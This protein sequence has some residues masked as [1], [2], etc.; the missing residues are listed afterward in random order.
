MSTFDIITDAPGMLRSEAVNIT[1]SFNRTSPTTGRVSWNIPTPAAGCTSA[2]QAYCGIVITV[3]NKPISTGTGP[4]D[5]TVYNSDPTADAN[6]FA[7]DVIGTAKVVGAFYNDRTTTFLD[8]TGLQPNT[9]VYVS[10]FPTDCQF[11]YYY[12]GVHAYS[13]N[14][15]NRGTDG[16]HGHQVLVLNSSASQMGVQPTDAT[17]LVPGTMYSFKIQLGLIP[18]PNR[19]IDQTECLPQP[20][21][22]TITV[23]GADAQT[24]ADLVAAINKQFGLLSNAAL[25]PTS[26]NTNGYYFNVTQKLLFQWNG[27][28]HVAVPCIISATAPNAVLT[29]GY[30][31]NTSTNVMSVWTGSAWSTV[32]VISFSSDPTQPVADSSYWFDGTHAY[33]WNGTTWCQVATYIQ[34]TDP[35]LAT[36]PVAGSYWYDT[37]DHLLYRWNSTLEMWSITPV[38][39]YGT[40]P[41]A[42]PDGTL[43]LNETAGMLYELGIPT[44]GW[45]LQSNLAITEVA[46][47][48]PAPGKFWYNP[49]TKVLNQW[50]GTGLVWVVQDVL[51][52]PFDPTQRSFCDLW[53]NTNSSVLSVWNAVNSSWVVANHVYQQDTDPTLT[54]VI[55]QGTA[56]YHNGVLA[57]YEGACFVTVTYVSWPTDPTSTIPDG[58][59]WHNL[60]NS[61]WYVRD[62]GAW[63]QIA[64]TSSVSDPNTLPSGTFWYT[65]STMAL[66]MWNGS[67]WV[68][69]TYSS[70]PLTP[71]KGTLWYD[72]ASSLLKTWDGT[73]WVLATPVATVELDCHGNML[74]TDTNIGSTSFVSI[75]DIT[76]F[77]SLSV[78]NAIHDQVPGQD[79][80][81]DTPTYAEIGIGTDGNDAIRDEIANEIR[82]ELGYPV[83]DVELTKEQ[84]NYAMDRALSEFRMRSSIAYRRGFFFMALKANEQRYFLTNKI[85]GMNKIVD[86]TGVYRCTSAFLAS[87]HGAGVY[88][89]IV[90]QHLYNMGTFDLLSYHMMA[91][92][93]K[94]MEILFAARV[95]YNWNEQTREIWLHQR[96]NQAE[97]MVMI[98]A[99]VERTEQDL[100]SDRY[101][102]PWLRRYALAMCRIML[103]EIRGKFA[104]LPGA[105]GST[106][107]NS[108]TLRQAGQAEIELCIGEI[109]DFVADRPEE[110]GMGTTFT[111]G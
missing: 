48:T 61:L 16:T 7:G 21:V 68:S 28:A 44:T 65:P 54:P 64:P 93:T 12:A 17:S 83:M 101:T 30:W 45:N 63:T 80:A 69:V 85:S 57:I 3:D 72:T 32:T 24:Y 95:T 43:W 9:P 104:S 23:D 82:Y 71:T 11:R 14:Y 19:P 47:A 52:F 73:A 98:D 111:F 34:A 36:V 13:Q 99:S 110:F 109:D 35:S 20:H 58:T 40:Q 67:T 91:D 97:P 88:G 26:P 94:L 102:K 49:T 53:W 107:L 78:T 89:Q 29:G 39:Q 55:P 2:N 60:T 70:A 37:N 76:L 66:Q 96:Y 84:M 100:F 8:I 59:V 86:V 18:T 25:G 22:Y 74:F 33:L 62:S 27:S 42:L 77:Q 51:V 50:D 5:G 105:N 31:Y 1:L 103:A 106:T 81:S 108:D 10:G 87:A 92:Y 41:S 46:P 38:I 15:T 6:L 4:T 79:G 56:W 75:A 90:V